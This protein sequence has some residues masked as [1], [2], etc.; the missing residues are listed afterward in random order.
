MTSAKDNHMI[1]PPRAQVTTGVSSAMTAPMVTTAAISRFLR[2]ARRRKPKRGSAP[3]GRIAVP[4]ITNPRALKMGW[5]V[6][7]A[8]RR[9]WFNLLDRPGESYSVSVRGIAAVRRDH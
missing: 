8:G 9:I 6:E 2:A 7:D 3:L 5:M 4:G 1:V